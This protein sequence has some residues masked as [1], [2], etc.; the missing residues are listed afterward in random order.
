MIPA[1]QIGTIGRR[2]NEAAL[3]EDDPFRWG[4]KL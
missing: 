1:P 3:N 2:D 4:K